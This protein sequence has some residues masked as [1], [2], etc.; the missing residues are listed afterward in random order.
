MISNNTIKASSRG[1]T[2]MNAMENVT[3]SDNTINMQAGANFS[4]SLD[5]EW[6]KTSSANFIVQNN[7]IRGFKSASETGAPP[8]LISA[9]SISI[10]DNDFGD[11]QINGASNVTL[12]GNKIDANIGEHGI[13]FY[14][15]LPNS[16]IKNNIITIYPSKTPL[17]VECIKTANNVSLSSS[18]IIEDNNTCNEK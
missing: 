13:L 2:S 16:T 12:S 10:L 17:Q 5:S 3:I 1:I 14:S 18:V 15:D 4:L 9:N 11:V 7:T 6:S 8:S